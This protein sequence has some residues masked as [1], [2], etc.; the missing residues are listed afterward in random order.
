MIIRH[1]TE[2]DLDTV[3]KILQESGS[4]LIR[5]SDFSYILMFKYF[6]ELCFLIEKNS[7]PFGYV[8]GFRTSKPEVCYL[9]QIGIIKELQGKGYSEKLIRSFFSAA[10][11]L[12]CS[13]VQVSIE[14]E[15]IASIKAFQ[16]FSRKLAL[17]MKTLDTITFDKSDGSGQSIDQVYS[18]RI[19]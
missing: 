19:D 4:F 15:N 17:N 1:I 5:H 6:P 16:S 13:E 3:I 10:K 9:W 18:I 8:I 12:G 11:D 14:P 2:S 7:R